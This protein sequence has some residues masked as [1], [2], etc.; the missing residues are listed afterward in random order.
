[1]LHQINR[2]LLAFCQIISG[3]TIVLMATAAFI[4]S[5]GRKIDHPL[6]GASEIVSYALMLFF[7]AAIPLVVK[8]DCHIRVGLFS[9]FYTAPLRRVE[10]FISQILEIL[11]ILAMAAFAW[12]ILDQAGRLSRF[13]TESVYFQMPVGPWV[14]AA[15]AF[16]ALALWFAIQ[17]LFDKPQAHSLDAEES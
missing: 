5:I 1:M 9:D 4:D 13:G 14:Y 17:S 15:F 8:A 10:G 6:P 12:M 3:S 2:A 16:T 11:E 7:F